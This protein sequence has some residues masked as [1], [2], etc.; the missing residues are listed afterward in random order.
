MYEV[1]FAHSLR[2]PVIHIIKENTKVPFDIKDNRY[3]EYKNTISGTIKLK[4]TF[5]NFVIEAIENPG[6][7]N[8][9]ISSS[10]DTWKIIEPEAHNVEIPQLLEKLT[11]EVRKLNS[12]TNLLEQTYRNQ[13]TTD[14]KLYY[15]ENKRMNNNFINEKYIKAF[16]DSYSKYE[17]I[18][19]AIKDV[20]FKLN[21]TYDSSKSIFESLEL[22]INKNID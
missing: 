10:M 14:D 1:A 3:I 4:E 21:I 6:D 9:P 13:N 18:D 12:R 11:V 22:A 15:Y 5:N 7:V 2:K 19:L 17:D 20:A 16:L 8:N